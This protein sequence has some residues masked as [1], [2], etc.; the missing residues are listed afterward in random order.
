MKLIEILEIN[1]KLIEEFVF[2]LHILNHL[3]SEVFFYYLKLLFIIQF[4]KFPLHAW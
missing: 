4:K 3:V 2:L 1:V